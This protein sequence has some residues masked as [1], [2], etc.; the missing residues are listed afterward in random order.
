M[1]FDRRRQSASFL[2]TSH[3]YTSKQ[4]LIDI[5]SFALSRPHSN[6]HHTPRILLGAWSE[7]GSNAN[8]SVM[9]F[10]NITRFGFDRLYEPVSDEER[11]VRTDFTRDLN[12]Y[13]RLVSIIICQNAQSGE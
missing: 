6:R 9:R 11:H 8:D 2:A 5:K 10:P 13:L 1:N 12:F 3:D 4:L 7:S